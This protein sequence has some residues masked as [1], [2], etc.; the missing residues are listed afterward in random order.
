MAHRLLRDR[1]KV[2]GCERAKVLYHA[3]F[4]DHSPLDSLNIEIVE[5]FNEVDLFVLGSAQSDTLTFDDYATMLWPGAERKIPCL[6]INP[7]FEKL[8]AVGTA[9]S[10]GTVAELYVSMG[11]LWNGLVSPTKQSMRKH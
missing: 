2:H 7:D 4:S 11:D 10:A 1:S 3:D 6:C 9:F 8:V 5:E